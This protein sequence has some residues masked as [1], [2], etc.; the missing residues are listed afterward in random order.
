MYYLHAE[1]LK[2]ILSGTKRIDDDGKNGN[3]YLAFWEG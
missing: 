2:K 1:K 3:A